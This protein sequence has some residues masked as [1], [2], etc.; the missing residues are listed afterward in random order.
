MNIKVSRRQTI[1][2]ILLV[3]CALFL[4]CLWP[5][6][7]INRSIE[8][9][10]GEVYLEE[11]AP[12][13]AANNIAQVFVAD[14][15]E[16][17]YVNL[18]VCNDMAGEEINF[19]LYDGTLTQL[20]SKNI[21]IGENSTFPGMIKLPVEYDLDPG[22]AYIYTIYGVNK[23]LIVGIQEN[24]PV[25]SITVGGMNYAGT[26]IS[27]R[28]VIINFVYTKEF[29]WWQIAVMYI[30][31]LLLF[32]AVVVVINRLSGVLPIYS[33]QGST[34]GNK[35]NEE[36]ITVQRLLQ[37]TLLP[38]CILVGIAALISIFPLY[39]FR[40]EISSILFYYLGVIL[41]TG[42]IAYLICYKREDSKPLISYQIL[43]NNIQK[44]L[45]V[46]AIGHVFWYC[47]EYMNGLYEIHHI[48][49]SRRVL[50]W[51]LL[52]LI[53]TY[54]QKELFNI[55]NLVWLV[56][57]GIFAYFYAKPYVGVPE[58]EL[59]YRLNA[60]II[61]IGGVVLINMIMSI[62]NM[63]RKKA[64]PRSVSKLNAAI[65]AVLA[66]VMISFS[67]ARWW[68]AYLVVVCGLIIF[69]LAFW[70][71]ADKY[72]IY[73]CDGILFNF[74]MMLA[75][76]LMHRPYYRFVYYRYNMTYFTVT[77]TAT[78]MSL[79]VSAALVKFIIR[80]KSESDKRRLIPDL[81]MFGAAVCY[82]IYTLARTAFLCIG[83]TGVVTIV[84]LA[85]INYEKGTRIKKA[86]DNVALLLGAVLVM[87]PITF[88]ATRIVPAI[89][90][91]PV[92][93][94]YEHRD[95][96]MY[97]GTP[98]DCFGYMDIARFF[99][100]FGSKILGVGETLTEADPVFGQDNIFRHGIIREVASAG[101]DDMLITSAEGETESET[102][103]DDRPDFLKNT[104]WTLDEWHHFLEMRDDYYF[105]TDD[106]YWL[107]INGIIDVDL[108]VDASNGR[109]DIFKSYFNQLNLWGHE[110]MGAI[111][112]DGSEAAHAHNIYLQILFDFGI[113]PGIY[114]IIVM[115]YMGI[116]SLVRVVKYHKKN[117][118]LW[119]TP[120]V[121]L[122]FLTAGVVEWVFHAC[123]PL[124]LAAMMAILPM[125]F[126]VTENEKSI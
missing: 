79:V 97:K 6:R 21:K 111:L 49:A 56:A 114:V 94:E 13:N 60:Y 116:T 110:E 5:C 75:F 3:I 77:M 37:F 38:V 10:S 1:I 15:N 85:F 29:N 46:V 50:I 8:V 45:I 108:P 52:M 118:Y 89:V 24:D 74:V 64:V 35:W 68:P 23:D 124:G 87:F 102:E 121:L 67:N 71:D 18:Y 103:E 57:S 81:I 76:S 32:T 31:T 106:E 90:D 20:C 44:W 40:K 96:T 62:I 78:H 72:L 70:K 14:G 27:D 30:I 39:L 53:F 47:F 36:Y 100:V 115:A 59:T 63:I 41:L 84:A 4:I 25:T 26:E 101:E 82:Q 105:L 69:R 112:D 17:E 12:A 104:P 86:L 55:I 117:E 34:I 98:T 125:F 107:F 9:K 122:C 16:L 22:I 120:V 113:I 91:D 33:I 73:L 58:D 2:Y 126:K 80:Y 109:I 95:E 43:K 92:I 66:V 93:Y 28:D 119:L 7:F 54:S 61:V 83:V 123:N 42:L 88:T 11:S 65:F 99:E 48:Y 19:T 51:I